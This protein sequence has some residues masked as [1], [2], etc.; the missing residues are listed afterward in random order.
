MLIMYFIPIVILSPLGIYLLVYNL[1][2]DRRAA[3]FSGLIFIFNNVLPWRVSL[4]QV[5][6]AMVLALMPVILNLYIDSLNK[7]SYLATIL[8]AVIISIS[9]LY[10]LRTTYLS[11]L[12]ISTYGL[13]YILTYKF[14]IAKIIQLLK[15]TV[16]IIA[17]VGITQTYQILPVIVIGNTTPLPLSYITPSALRALSRS[18]LFQILVMTHY[19]WGLDEG[20]LVFSVIIAFLAFLDLLFTKDSHILYFASIYLLFAFLAK[21]SV[22][23]FGFLNSWLFVHFPFF[24]WFRE[25]LVF[26]MPQ[27]IPF[28]VLFGVSASR[29]SKIAEYIKMLTRE[30]AG[31][32]LILLLIILLIGDTWP[33]SYIATNSIPRSYYQISSWLKSQL[34]GRVL[35]LPIYPHYI[36]TYSSYQGVYLSQISIPFWGDYIKQSIIYNKTNGIAELLA[37]YNV[38]YVVI[39]PPDDICWKFHTFPSASYYYSILRNNDNFKLI[40]ISNE[41][42]VLINRFT[43]PQIRLIDK[44]GLL[45][46]NMQDMIKLIELTNPNEWGFLFAEQLS[47]T[48][49]DLDIYSAIIYSNGRNLEEVILEMVNE[50]Y[51][52]PLWNYAN[53]WGYDDL[54]KWVVGYPVPSCLAQYITISPKGLLTNAFPEQDAQM[55]FQFIAPQSDLYE[56]WV[57]SAA[58]SPTDSIT[59]AVNN[60]ILKVASPDLNTSLKWVRAGSI[61][62]QKGTASISITG[63][64]QVFIDTIVIVPEHVLNKIKNQVLSKLKLKS[65]T[66]DEFTKHLSS[67]NETYYP[68]RVQWIK[69]ST[70]SINLKFIGNQDKSEMKGR[71]YYFLVFSEPYDPFWKFSSKSYEVKSIP[72]YGFI[73][74]FIISRDV[75]EGEIVYSPQYFLDLGVWI[76]IFGFLLI[77]LLLL[78]LVIKNK[79][80]K[81]IIL[82]KQNILYRYF[83]RRDIP[84]L[85]ELIS[86]S[87]EAMPLYFHSVD[88]KTRLRTFILRFTYEKYIDRLK[89]FALLLSPSVLFTSNYDRT[90]IVAIDKENGKVIG[91]V[92]LSPLLADSWSLDIIV[93][94]KTYR[95]RNIGSTLLELAKKHVKRLGANY[96]ITSTLSGS[97]QANFFKKR[98]FTTSYIIEEMQH[99]L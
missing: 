20:P 61:K 82:E 64:G 98:G 7:N 88:A 1:F 37:L 35:M 53:Y 48:P 77:L 71:M 80:R 55:N 97:A 44:I 72:A 74:M 32:L 42:K 17:I 12:L 87:P 25:P 68:S 99:M 90:V 95:G 70:T 84:R 31:A 86:S 11:L 19:G 10:D 58:S 52:I 63:H 89:R 91:A 39:A 2:Q 21:G 45:V 36:Y 3:F 28:A 50:T 66:L 13:Y 94:D 24:N 56:I 49:E 16:L 92:F 85:V 29:L 60:N 40:N 26:Q 62:L 34:P 78:I 46:G 18:N 47:L 22:E 14:K 27:L 75:Q 93:V 8:C 96:L 73:N 59:I 15:T 33:I 79:Q 38:K 9:I 51:R 69:K 83:H 67:K 4:G 23:P 5:T 57:R 54:G 30:L 76:S 65:F 6:F 41:T 43:L 81:S